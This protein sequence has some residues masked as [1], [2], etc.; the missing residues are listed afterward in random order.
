MRVQIDWRQ[1]GRT[2]LRLLVPLLV[3]AALSIGVTIALSPPG[4]NWAVLREILI[5]KVQ[6][7][8]LVALAGLLLIAGAS[9]V[10]ALLQC[11]GLPWLHLQRGR[12]SKLMRAIEPSR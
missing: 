3:I 9:F 6:I 4:G 1:V 2:Y 8:S 12:F 11:Y 5:L 7:Y 10:A